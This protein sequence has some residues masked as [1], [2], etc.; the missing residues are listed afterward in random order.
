MRVPLSVGKSCR[1][2]GDAQMTSL[3]PD[4]VWRGGRD[5]ESCGDLELDT[6]KMCHFAVA[7]G[8]LVAGVFGSLALVSHK[9]KNTNSMWLE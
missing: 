3:L 9:N 4:P 2:F 8:G 6:S 7:A 1:G 5:L